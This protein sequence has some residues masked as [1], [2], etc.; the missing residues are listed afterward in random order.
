MPCA[1]G[2]ATSRA[3]GG[4]G[5]G[6]RGGARARTEPSANVVELAQRAPLDRPALEALVASG[7]CDGFG[8]PR[9]QLLWRL[10]L[11]PRS[12][13][14]GAG[15][16]GAPAGA[17]ARADARDARAPRADAVGAHARRLPAD[18][19]VRRAA[20]ARASAPAPARRGGGERRPRAPRAQEPVAVA[21]LVVARQRP[22]TANGVVF[23]LLEDEHGQMNLVIPPGV[24]ALPRARARRAAPPRPGRF[25][26]FERNQNILVEELA[27]LHRSPAA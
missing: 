11:A 12:V 24:R 5:Q 1:S 17:P 4:A 9:R 21:G 27:T 6:V 3:W 7:A 18:E 2:S 19:H 13:S 22:A 25:E 23:M 26:R 20:P 16:R 10:G 15:R 8:W 14:V